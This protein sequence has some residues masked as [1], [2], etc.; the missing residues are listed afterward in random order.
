MVF[1]AW[2]IR[3]LLGRMQGEKIERLQAKKELIEMGS[4]AIPFLQQTLREGS[5]EFREALRL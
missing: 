2:R 1:T 3:R 4:A 5:L